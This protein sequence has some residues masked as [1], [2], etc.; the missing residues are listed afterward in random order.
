M[1]RDKEPMSEA[2]FYILLALCRPLHGYAIISV[3][4]EI[5]K[6]RLKLSSGTLYGIL[7][8]LEV[9]GRI[10]LTEVSGR[11]KHYT[12]T[13]EGR[14]ALHDECKRLSTIIADAEQNLF[15]IWYDMN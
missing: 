9:E 3:V 11:R 10:Q 8:R 2:M 14:I 5:S 12:L 6:G 4:E 13:K 1:T 15:S 7:T